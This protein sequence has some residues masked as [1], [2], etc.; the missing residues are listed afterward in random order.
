MIFLRLFNKSL[1]ILNNKFCACT[2]FISWLLGLWIINGKIPASSSGDDIFFSEIAWSI[3]LNNEHAYKSIPD[4][5]LLIH[6]KLFWPP[7]LSYLQFLSFKIFGLNQ[8]S[9]N[10]LK[11][12]LI[13]IFLILSLFYAK[14][15]LVDTQVAIFFSISFASVP[16]L[17]SYALHNRPENVY[18]LFIIISF[19]LCELLVKNKTQEKIAFFFSG[20]LIGLSII[21]Y[22]PL[23]FIFLIIGLLLAIFLSKNNSIV[24]N[25]ILIFI[26]QSVVCFFFLVWIYPDYLFAIMQLLE[27]GK[28]KYGDDW[29]KERFIYF[30]FSFFFIL[31][32]TFLLNKYSF[33][34]KNNSSKFCFITTIL[35][36]LSLFQSNF[37]NYPAFVFFLFGLLNLKISKSLNSIKEIN[38]DKIFLL[39][40]ISS[41]IIM[42]IL[43]FKS[44]EKGRNYNLFSNHLNNNINL[45]G[46]VITDRVAWLH[47]RPLLN[48][49]NLFEIY[50]K[51]DAASN[52]RSSILFDVNYSKKISSVV[53]NEHMYD[54]YYKTFPLFRA[55]MS[56]N[57]CS[58]KLIG[59]NAPYQVRVYNCKI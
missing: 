58:S 24:S 36:A 46:M 54:Y 14:K 37:V 48:Q 3:L 31:I 12:F 50:N 42:S 11:T 30:S 23:I 28:G 5:N 8:F 51:N 57:N 59:I 52:F 40:S 53:I 2:I 1:N 49:N 22:Y 35:F 6:I 32:S 33:P 47:L 56:S 38:L 15:K 29:M 27:I 13:S 9:M 55:L 18:V 26:G 44:F 17:L 43:V 25:L 16:I 39:L 21:T 41:M 45:S 4:D 10:F 20:V 7:V 19:I 34:T